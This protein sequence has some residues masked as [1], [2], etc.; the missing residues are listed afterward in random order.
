MSP[1]FVKFQNRIWI[2]SF[3]DRKEHRSSI[4]WWFPQTTGK[5]HPIFVTSSLRLCKF[6]ISWCL[7]RELSSLGSPS[8]IPIVI[9]NSWHQ[10]NK[11]VDL[12]CIIYYEENRVVSYLRYIL[13]VRGEYHFAKTLTQKNRAFPQPRF[14]VCDIIIR[15]RQYELIYPGTNPHVPN[16]S[17]FCQ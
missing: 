1:N 11:S 15:G 13:S 12:E 7:K 5:S 14:C 9:N 10:E 6:A 17:I 4:A 8:N 3:C 2:P 16:L